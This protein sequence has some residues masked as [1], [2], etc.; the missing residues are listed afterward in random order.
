M[1]VKELL[2]EILKI[3]VKL[4]MLDPEKDSIEG[5]FLKDLSILV[6]AYEEELFPQKQE[7]ANA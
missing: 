6:C 2:G 4:M 3:I 1:Q 5:R 7:E